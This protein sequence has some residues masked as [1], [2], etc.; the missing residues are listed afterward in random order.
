[1]K[2]S[3]FPFSCW[4]WVELP[5]PT[6]LAQVLG[7]WPVALESESGPSVAG[8]GWGSSRSLGVLHQGVWGN[9]PE[10]WT[11]TLFTALKDQNLLPLVLRATVWGCVVKYLIDN[12][13]PKTAIICQSSSR[14][15]DL[16]FF[17]QQ[18]E[19]WGPQEGLKEKASGLEFR[20]SPTASMPFSAD[21]F[22]LVLQAK[23]WP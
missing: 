15:C 6:D 22:C 23:D 18:W 8:P 10:V 14:T 17:V 5:L 9:L 13:F 3:P 20:I 19:D 12:S 1:M 4:S 11:C 7:V 21:W 2:V 16:S